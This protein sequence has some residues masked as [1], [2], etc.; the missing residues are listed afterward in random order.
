MLFTG[1]HP[2]HITYITLHTLNRCMFKVAA[3]QIH[4]H[5]RVGLLYDIGV[6]GMCGNAHTALGTPTVVDRKRTIIGVVRLAR[7]RG[8][9]AHIS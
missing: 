8:K 5:A 9:A 4:A 6:A 7:E 2:L 1:V 3:W